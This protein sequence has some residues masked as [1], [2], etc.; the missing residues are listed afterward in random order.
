MVPHDSKSDLPL[1]SM[2]VF[3]QIFQR[4]GQCVSITCRSFLGCFLL[5]IS[6]RLYL[7]MFGTVTWLDWLYFLSMVKI[8]ITLL[9]Y[10][11]Q[12]YFNYQRQS[13]QG[14]TIGTVLFDFFGGAFSLVQM[15]VN[16]WDHGMLF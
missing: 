2:Y 11:P 7:A 5:L 6:D 14:W 1:C 3:L 10:M 12:A 9:K 13:T 16:A 8:S 15:L 4:G